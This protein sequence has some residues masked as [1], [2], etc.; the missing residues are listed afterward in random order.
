MFAIFMGVGC[1]G[2]AEPRAA[3]RTE[4]AAVGARAAI[5]LSGWPFV[6][7]KVVSE[8]SHLPCRRL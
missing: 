6:I 7:G 3:R 4:E 2:G 5:P 1:D 8:V